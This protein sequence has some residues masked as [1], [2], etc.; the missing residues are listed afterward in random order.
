MHEVHETWKKRKLERNFKLHRPK[1]ILCSVHGSGGGRIVL[2]LLHGL[3]QFLAKTLQKEF[4]YRLLIYV[5]VHKFFHSNVNYSLTYTREGFL[6]YNK[7]H[8]HCLRSSVAHKDL[9]RRGVREKLDARR[10][11]NFIPFNLL[12]F[13]D[14]PRLEHVVEANGVRWNAIK[15]ETA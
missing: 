3:R 5:R 11:I 10:K 1:S 7:S 14:W 13:S 8:V 15:L 9:K 6:P 4:I 2:L 12:L